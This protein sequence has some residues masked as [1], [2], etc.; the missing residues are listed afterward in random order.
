MSAAGKTVAER[1]ADMRWVVIR[2]V[3]MLV[4]VAQILWATGR[5]ERPQAS[6]AAILPGTT[7]R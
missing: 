4:M 7:L 1:L 3:G 6:I 2:D 5:P